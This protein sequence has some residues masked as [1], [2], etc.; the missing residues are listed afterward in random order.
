MPHVAGFMPWLG[1][2]RSPSP[3]IRRSTITARWSLLAERPATFP[4]RRC[5]LPSGGMVGASGLSSPAST[6]SRQERVSY[7]TS[8]PRGLSL[9][10]CCARARRPEAGSL[11]Q[12][13]WARACA[14][15]RTG[16]GSV[17]RQS[18]AI[19]ARSPAALG[20]VLDRV[21]RQRRDVASPILVL[22]VHRLGTSPAA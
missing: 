4:Y 12:T 1:K 16:A 10:W 14:V 6:G 21:A 7:T 11:E 3:M 19:P 22:H 20:S 5:R 13:A 15:L 9:S 18:A 8:E 2:P 17:G